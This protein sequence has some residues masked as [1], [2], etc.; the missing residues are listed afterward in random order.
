MTP[1]PESALLEAG[2]LRRNCSELVELKCRD[3]DS[4]MDFG[5]SGEWECSTCQKG[6]KDSSFN[7]VVKCGLCHEVLESN[8]PIC[9]KDS[10]PLVVRPSGQLWCSTCNDSVNAEQRE[11]FSAKAYL[12]PNSIPAFSNGESLWAFGVNDSSKVSV[13]TESEIRRRL[14]IGELNDST[15]LSEPGKEGFSPARDFLAFRVELAQL[16]A[17]RQAR[18]SAERVN[19]EA[20][21]KEAER[22][23]RQAAKDEEKRRRGEASIAQLDIGRSRA[24]VFFSSVL[25]VIGLLLVNG[26]C[27]G[28]L[29]ALPKIGLAIGAS[30][31]F[32][33]AVLCK[34]KEKIF[35]ADFWILFAWLVICASITSAISSGDAHFF[36]KIGLGIFG[37]ISFVIPASIFFGSAIDKGLIAY[38][39]IL[40]FAW[41]YGLN[42]PA[43]IGFPVKINADTQQTN[44]AEKLQKLSGKE[45]EQS[46]P[47]PPLKARV[48]DLTAT[49]TATQIATLEEAVAR[50]ER[51]SGAQLAILMVP[52]TQS[53]SIDQ[54]ANRVFASWK[55]GRSGFN[56]GV[57]IVVDQNYRRVTILVGVGLESSL[58]S[59][60]VIDVEMVPHFKTGNF[61]GGL[62]AAVAAINAILSPLEAGPTELPSGK[63]DSEKN[64]KFKGPANTERPKPSEHKAEQNSKS[65]FYQN[66]HDLVTKVITVSS[67]MVENIG[68]GVRNIFGNAESEFSEARIRAEA[69]T[70]GDFSTCGKAMLRAIDPPRLDLVNLAASKLEL[71][72]RGIAHKDRQSARK[73]NAAGLQAVRRESYEPATEL[74]KKAAL[75]DPADAEVQSN[76]AYAAV[77]A[78]Q[79]QLASDAFA[80]SLT[81][82]PK[83]TS[84][85]IPYADLLEKKQMKDDAVRALL[86]GYEFSNNK[87]TT[88]NF[89]SERVTKAAT[90]HEKH[91]YLAALK[92][93]GISFDASAAK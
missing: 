59:K 52:T 55:L 32:G 77:R 57:L 8:R 45:A 22:R 64:V 36:S 76:L 91:I 47:V 5:S 39:L 43:W 71:V 48:S 17:D 18:E 38:G 53:E 15:L 93:L 79:L 72:G 23:T 62:E 88:V 70:C 56:D 41:G 40:A 2:F 66:A 46:I 60:R 20:V 86:L 33:V 74:F 82:S 4:P 25:S 50:V 75:A 90:E 26:V 81:L 58:D 67:G 31:A 3:C 68:R 44:N 29:S 24:Q 12:I 34:V 6:P 80:R 92:K 42:Y 84:A 14:A 21:R 65:G 28:N 16:A 87:A 69:M 78:G 89:F 35:T 37:I 10:T 61:F 83:R 54:Y 19:A 51:R 27:Y 85:W 13:A 9:R 49:L 1:L 63:A 11:C 73:L 30:I 7:L